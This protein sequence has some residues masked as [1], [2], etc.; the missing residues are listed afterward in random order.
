[1]IG[2]ATMG[3]WWILL[4]IAVLIVGPGGA[5]W[6]AVKIGLNSLRDD[7]AETKDRIRKIEEHLSDVRTRVAVLESR[8][9]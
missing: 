8:A 7:V 9:Q 1:M 6:V 5:A 2:E 3:N 4:S